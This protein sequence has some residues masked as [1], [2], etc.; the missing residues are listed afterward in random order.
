[1]HK[2][3]SEGIFFLLTYVLP[4]PKCLTPANSS[5]LALSGF[6]THERNIYGRAQSAPPSIVSPA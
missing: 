1:M 4:H 5:Y 2:K 6:R 3:V